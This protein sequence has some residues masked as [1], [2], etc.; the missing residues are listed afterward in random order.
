MTVKEL[1]NKLQQVPE[2]AI[3][4]YYYNNSYDNCWSDWVE[5]CELDYNYFEDENVVRIG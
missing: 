5:V 3:V 4:E 2:D 1:I